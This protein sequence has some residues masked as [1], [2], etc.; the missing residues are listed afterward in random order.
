MVK[1]ERPGW[2]GVI[3]GVL[4]SGDSWKWTLAD[5]ECCAGRRGESE[6]NRAA[7]EPVDRVRA[8]RAANQ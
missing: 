6:V 7:R 2:L 4:H 5:R 8:A 1:P 3:A